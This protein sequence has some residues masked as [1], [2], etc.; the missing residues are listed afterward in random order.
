[1]Q[2]LGNDP[3]DWLL[4]SGVIENWH[5]TSRH[6][7]MIIREAIGQA[8]EIE[9]ETKVSELQSDRDPALTV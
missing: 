9:V 1:M 5:E 3:E 7:D 6:P 8:G 2:A 4:V